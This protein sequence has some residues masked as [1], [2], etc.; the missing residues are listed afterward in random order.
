[1]SS[2]ELKAK[3]AKIIESKSNAELIIDILAILE[4]N[5]TTSKLRSIHALNKTWTHIV[6]RG[7]LK[8]TE[9]KDNKYNQWI[10]EVFDQT[11]KKLITLISADD[12]RVSDL[13][14]STVVGF[15]VTTHEIN[16][17]GTYI[18][19]A[20]GSKLCR[21][22]NIVI[23]FG[24]FCFVDNR[25]HWNG[26]EVS[27]L[28]S[29]LSV[30]LSE[31]SDK[32]N[33]ITRFQEYLEYIDVKQHVIHVTSKIVHTARSKGYSTKI[34]RANVMR[35]LELIDFKDPKEID[36]SSTLLCKKAQYKY[37]HKTVQKVF[38]LLWE[39]FLK[40]NSSEVDLYK[41]MLI[42]L[43]D[44]V[45]PELLRPLMLTD[46]LVESY[47]VGG[48]ISLLALNGVF[49]LMAK[50]NLEYPDFYKVRII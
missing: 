29:I 45:M 20:L 9:E 31:N 17:Q 23:P 4:E 28:R 43:H 18:P 49:H 12:T 35:L 42:I 15:V 10:Q 46:F 13:A 30:L 48:S 38:S 37:D 3:V 32:S 22:L 26:E 6:R 5:S 19:R 11:C 24:A 25:N 44:K 2:I 34:F 33:Q 47:N 41:R 40:L 16:N 1:M 36:E 27:L 7:D 8:V 14:L 39:D 21:Y 50:Y